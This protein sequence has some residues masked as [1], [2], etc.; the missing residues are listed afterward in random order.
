MITH[1]QKSSLLIWG[2][3]S[4]WPLSQRGLD[5]TELA[6]S[7]LTVLVAGHTTT[8]SLPFFPSSG[9]NH[10]QCSL[11]L[12]MKGWPGWV[13]LS[14]LKNT[15]M[16]H[17]PKVVTNPS[18]KRAQHCLTL[19]Y[20]SKDQKMNEMNEW[21][22]KRMIVVFCHFLTFQFVPTTSCNKRRHWEIL[23]TVKLQKLC[24]Q[25]S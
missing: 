11:H 16:V 9:Q 6:A 13:G 19:F 5:P 24:G 23:G 21:I 15:D 8:Q 12:P 4:L 3:S 17:L 10:C 18:T 22:K 20:Y 25:Q 2:S 1:R 14:G 7:M